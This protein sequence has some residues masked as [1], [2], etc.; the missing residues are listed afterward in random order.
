MGA[1]GPEAVLRGSTG[2]G[3][4]AIP[5]GCTFQSATL[6]LQITGVGGTQPTISVYTAAGAWT[7]TGPP[8][9]GITWDN[10]PGYTGSALDTKTVTEYGPWSWDVSGAWPGT[11]NLGLVLVQD[12]SIHGQVSFVSREESV[13]TPAYL[14]IA[15]TDATDVPEP[16]TLGLLAALALPGLALWRKRRR[17][18]HR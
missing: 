7:E 13:G 11:G 1:H 6:W 4:G 8:G 17:A 16:G 9:I 14:D 5:A 18:A 15:Y 2:R 12:S 3:G 10:Q